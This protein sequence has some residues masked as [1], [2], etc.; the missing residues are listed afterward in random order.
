MNTKA[1]SN[2]VIT[3]ELVPGRTVGDACIIFSVVNIGD[4]KLEISALSESNQERAMIHGMI[5]RISDAAAIPRDTTTGKSATPQEKFDAMAKLVA[6]YESGTSEWSR[7]RESGEGNSGGLLLA[8]LTRLSPTKSKDE[9]RTW[10]KS[11]TRAQLDA[12]RDTDRI[13]KVIDSIRPAPS[14]SV[15]TDA[16]LAGIGI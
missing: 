12:L 9:I 8:A 3:H 10:M 4:I 7:V 13:K 1:K 14:I 5:Q 6:H 16:M 15:D 2:S 11:Q